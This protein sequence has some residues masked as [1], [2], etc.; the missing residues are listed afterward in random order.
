MCNVKLFQI[1][2]AVPVLRL[3]RLD[4]DLDSSSLAQPER[5]LGMS[6]LVINDQALY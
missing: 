1:M 2:Y 5:R 3:P 4:S 6:P